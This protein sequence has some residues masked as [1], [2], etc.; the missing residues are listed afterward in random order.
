MTT[1]ANSR[2]RP[3]KD[4]ST[5]LGMLEAVIA[6]TPE[7]PELRFR[8]ICVLV[9]SPGPMRRREGLATSEKPAEAV[10]D[11]AAFLVDFWLDFFG[12]AFAVLADDFV[13]VDL[14]PELGVA[15]FVVGDA[16]GRDG[17]VGPTALTV[18]TPIALTA[19]AVT[20][21]TIAPAR[22][23]RTRLVIGEVLSVVSVRHTRLTLLNRR[24][25]RFR[26]ISLTA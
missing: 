24:G 22:P 12:V 14:V 9:P 6:T 8:S 18:E 3:G 11:G 21:T 5:P 23:I 20:P 10:L 1:G 13:P 16:D 26:G 7:N 4:R 25:G 15:A 17:T 19:M 2:M